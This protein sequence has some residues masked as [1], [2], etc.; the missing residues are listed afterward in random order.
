MKQLTMFQLADEESKYSTKVEAPVYNPRGIVPDIRL[1]CDESK[2]KMLIEEINASAVNDEIKSFLVKAASR[3]IV[4]NYERIADFYCYADKPTQE[5]MERSG[6][7][8]IDFDSA[9]AN[10]F[11]K[12]CEDIRKQYL[13]EYDEQ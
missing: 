10:G 1:L 8:I 3:H 6:L 12:I 5:L 2:T 11:I 9:I 13:E 7:V 4:F